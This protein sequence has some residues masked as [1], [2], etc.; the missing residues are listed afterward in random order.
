[1]GLSTQEGCTPPTGALLTGKGKNAGSRIPGLGP[2]PEI[3]CVGDLGRTSC[4]LGGLAL[5]VYGAGT[6][7]LSG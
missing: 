6:A 2:G 3:G 1:M 4:L 7:P 5:P